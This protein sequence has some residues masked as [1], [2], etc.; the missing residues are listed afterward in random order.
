M[1]QWFSM[2]LN[3]CACLAGLVLLVS[4]VKSGAP[5]DALSTPQPAQPTTL[6][7]PGDSAIDDVFSP[8][9]YFEASCARC[10]GSYGRAYGE[11][12]GKN[13]DE[14]ALFRFV[15]EMTEGP[16]DEPLDG[17]DLESLV[18]YHRSL[19][20]G[21]P[22]V[23][24]SRHADDEVVGEVTPGATV[25]IIAKGGAAIEAVVSGHQFVVRGVAAREFEVVAELNG[26]ETRLK[27]RSGHSH[28][29]P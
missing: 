17:A 10:H 26:K 16:A 20:D 1:G 23:F 19:I 18:A 25:R 8:I 12:F 3:C 21:R 27:S 4:C 2:R 29:L 7:Q 5:D 6:E 28:R 14:R 24:V 15:K 11:E 9:A 22:F 13:L